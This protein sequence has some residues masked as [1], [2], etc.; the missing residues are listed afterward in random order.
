MRSQ[1]EELKRIRD[2]VLEFWSQNASCST[3]VTQLS[4]T[5]TLRIGS[6]LDFTESGSET[7]EVMSV[8]DQPMEPP[9]NP[10]PSSADDP[11]ASVIGQINNLWAADSDEETDATQ[12]QE[13]L[14]S[15]SEEEKKSPELPFNWADNK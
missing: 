12:D 4:D 10:G 5:S 7:V 3:S 14:L 1:Q 9:P 13:L 11:N 6:L 8:T 15:E 2:D